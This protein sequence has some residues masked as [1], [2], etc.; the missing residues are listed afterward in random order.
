MIGPAVDLQKSKLN[1]SNAAEEVEDWIWE[2]LDGVVGTAVLM[3]LRNNTRTTTK[4]VFDHFDSGDDYAVT[5]TVVPVR[6][7]RYGDE[8]LVSRSQA[9]R[10][11]AR[12]E[13][14]RRVHLDFIRIEAIAAVHPTSDIDAL[15]PWAFTPDSG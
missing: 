8:P 12:V 9:K 10:L 5:E 11:L 1:P 2:R 4:E 3:K 15:M 6:A 14:F 13:Q 7:V